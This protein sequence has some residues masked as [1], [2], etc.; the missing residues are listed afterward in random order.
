MAWKTSMT[1]ILRYSKIYQTSQR[2]KLSLVET[3]IAHTPAGE[4]DSEGTQAAMI[5]PMP[6]QLR[7][8]QV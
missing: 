3:I 4:D 5:I 8:S 7:S 1:G 6:V 2:L